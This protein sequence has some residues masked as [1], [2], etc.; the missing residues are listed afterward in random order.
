[1]FS[2]RHIFILFIA[3]VAVVVIVFLTL[4]LRPNSPLVV[5]QASENK[6]SDIVSTASSS[7]KTSETS[8][9]HSPDGKM[10]LIMGKVTEEESLTYSFFVSEIPETSRK[11]IFKK[12]VSAD[13]MMQMSPNA[14]SP[15]NKYLFITEKSASSVNYF[16][17]RGDGESFSESEQYIDVVLHF[18]AKNTGYTL[19]E[20]TGWDSETLLHVYTTKEDGSRGPSFWFEV[21]S[22]N[23]IQ[24]A[25]H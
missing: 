11:L 5:P 16:V 2:F 6:V 1:M 13:S 23:T 19:S 10:N 15:D 14:W 20:I 8:E 12:T 9:V 25:S 4:T 24:L 18:V 3:I 21:P 17:F 7:E 22:K